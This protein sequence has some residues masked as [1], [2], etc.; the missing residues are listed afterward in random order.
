MRDIENI[1][2]KRIVYS[3]TT[4]GDSWRIMSFNEKFKI[5]EKIELVFDSMVRDKQRCLTTL[6]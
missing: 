2:S 3:F 5:T 6:F 4:M 1:Y